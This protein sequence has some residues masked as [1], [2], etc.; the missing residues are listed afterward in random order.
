MEIKF[1][2]QYDKR[3]FFKAVRMANQ[4]AGN[5]KRFLWFMMMFAVGALVL[6]VYRVFETGDLAGNALLLVAAVIMVL[7]VGGI[8]L[9]PLVSAQKMWANPGTRRVLSGQVTNRGIVYILDEGRNEILWD[10]IIRIRKTEDVV[11]LVRNDGLLLVFPQKFF[12]RT[13][14]WRKFNKMV[15]NKIGRA[16]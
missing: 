15:E 5:Q 16:A 10:R 1:Q 7:V 9:R 12:K 2:G 14:D 8:F 11:A 13:S 4:P 6:L 3:V